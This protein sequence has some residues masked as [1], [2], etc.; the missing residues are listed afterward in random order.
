MATEG[1]SKDVDMEDAPAEEVSAVELY[2]V[3]TSWLYF[4]I[5]IIIIIIINSR[6]CD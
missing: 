2:C 6:C 4:F 1:E 5:I 3:A